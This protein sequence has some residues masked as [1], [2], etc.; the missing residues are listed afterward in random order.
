[1]NFTVPTYV[2]HPRPKISPEHDFSTPIKRIN[3]EQ[4]MAKWLRSEAF[5][6][7]VDFIQAVNESCKGR[8]CF[9][10]TSQ[11]PPQPAG[12]I[13]VQMVQMLEDMGNWVDEIPPLESPQRFGNKAFK[14]WCKRLDENA[15]RL[16]RELLSD[17]NAS[18]AAELSAYL[19]GGFGN[20]TRIDYGSGHELSFIAWLLGLE[21][22]GVILEADLSTL[23][24]WVFP[25]YLGLVRRLQRVYMLEPA[26]SHGVWGLDDHQFIPYYWGSSQLLDHPHLRPK[27]VLQQDIVDHFQRDYMYF[28]CIA[29][30]NE[31]KKGPFY[32]HS[33]ML[34]DISGVPRWQKV[35]TGMLKMYIAEVL[36]KFPVV[37][38]L[39]F[40]SLLRFDVEASFY[41][42]R[43]S[44]DD[45]PTS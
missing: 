33:P 35:N 7:L 16:T 20:G 29:Y 36:A 25:K 17:T 9:E 10:G 5:V 8:K 1:M 41:P 15:E 24:L 13:L 39:V 44:S 37:Q 14:D 30:I 42:T 34:F 31:V 38:H 32:E 27:S 18:A 3:D 40:G 12:Q 11:Q 2:P 6:R 19:A 22:C 43:R 45:T 26:G 23:G 21:M 28:G 4:T